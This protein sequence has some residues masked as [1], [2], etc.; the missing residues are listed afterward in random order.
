V[1]VRELLK[2]HTT[3][4]NGPAKQFAGPFQLWGR[5]ALP[6]AIVR[7]QRQRDLRCSVIYLESDILFM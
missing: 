5:G 7:D 1:G 3:E 4:E 6:I 2:S